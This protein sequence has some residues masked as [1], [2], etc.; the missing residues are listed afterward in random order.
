MASLLPACHK[1]F[2]AGDR[3]VI[4]LPG[5]HRLIFYKGDDRRQLIV[6]GG[7]LGVADIY[8]G[9]AS[10]VSSSSH[11]KVHR[12][13]P[14]ILKVVFCNNIYFSHTRINAPLSLSQACHK[15]VKD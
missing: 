5:C 6:P 9:C 11:L 14:I 4:G 10:S 3:L 8:V 15:P 7:L 2:Q 13:H 12:H 1:P